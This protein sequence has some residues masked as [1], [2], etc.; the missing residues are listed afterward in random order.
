MG[1]R[2]KILA[3]KGLVCLGMDAKD[4]EVVEY[5]NEKLE[6]VAEYAKEADELMEEMAGTIEMLRECCTDMGADGEA[7]H[8]LHLYKQYKEG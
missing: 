5:A 3:E 1:L 6:D 8:T 4:I 2:E 7:A